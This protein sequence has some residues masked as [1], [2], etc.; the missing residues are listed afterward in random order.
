MA[1]VTSII[2][3]GDSHPNDG[4]ILPIATMHLWESRQIAWRCEHRHDGEDDEERTATWAV[5]GIDTVLED[6]LLTLAAVS[7]RDERVVELLDQAAGD[8]WRAEHVTIGEVIGEPSQELRAAVRDAV[9]RATLVVTVVGDSVISD[10]LRVLE[11]LESNL[12]VC[13]PTYWHRSNQWQPEPEI[14][15]SLP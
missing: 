4:G 10:Q 8:A 9:G 12:E 3:A 6:G 2:T 5:A 11:S 14:G 15:G 1:T 13:L 7:I